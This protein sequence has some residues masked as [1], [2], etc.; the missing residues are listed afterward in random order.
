MNYKLITKAQVEEFYPHNYDI[1]I[2]KDYGLFTDTYT[3]EYFKL[4]S[5]YRFFEDKYLENTLHLKEIND[6]VDELHIGFNTK[7]LY[8]EISNITGNY[9][10]IRNNIFLE[11]LTKEEIEEF[12]TLVKTS[13]NSSLI[14]FVK[15]TYKK[16]IMFDT[17][18]ASDKIVNYNTYGGFITYNNSL[19]IGVLA[20]RSENL[21]RFLKDKEVEYTSLLGI[22]VSIFLYEDMVEES[23]KQVKDIYEKNSAMREDILKKYPKYLPLGSIVELKESYQ[24]IMI[25]GYSQVDMIDKNIYDYNACLYPDGVISSKFNILF[26]H[27]DINKIYVLGLVDNETKQFLDNIE[28]FIGTDAENKKLIEGLE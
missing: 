19:V 2:L 20:S 11:R 16:L 3:D 23:I 6:K 17:T 1:S 26:N 24:K 9:V 12:K 21:L 15:K 4:Y 13:D 8:K 22:P 18:K 5:I 25:I 14:E 28:K 27:D 10:Y 7:V